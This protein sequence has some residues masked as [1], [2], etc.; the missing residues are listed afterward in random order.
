MD[1]CLKVALFSSLT[2]ARDTLVE[3]REHDNTHRP[4]SPLRN[5]TP[6]IVLRKQRWTSWSRKAIKQ[7]PRTFVQLQKTRG[8]T[9]TE[10]AMAQN[11]SNSLWWRVSRNAAF[12]RKW[13][14][15]KSLRLFAA[16]KVINDFENAAGAF[17][18]EA[19]I[20]RL[21]FTARHNQTLKAQARQLLRHGRLPRGQQFFQLGY[22][23]LP[24]DQM[25]QDHQTALMADGF[26]EI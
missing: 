24:G 16:K 23:F 22:G 7:N 21:A 5:L 1:E 12:F 3:K 13:V 19:V 9:Q 25:A 20:D 6:K 18:S 15:P 10:A 17:I 11:R 26:Q 8:L 14:S 2:M 4:H